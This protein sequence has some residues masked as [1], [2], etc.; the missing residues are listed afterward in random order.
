MSIMQSSFNHLRANVT[1]GASVTTAS[2]TAPFA[3]VTV[4]TASILVMVNGCAGPSAGGGGG[5][6][7]TCTARGCEAYVSATQ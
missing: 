7:D 2:H 5:G 3:S 1:F 6:V 4:N